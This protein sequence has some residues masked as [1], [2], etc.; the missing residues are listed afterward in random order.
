MLEPLGSVDI[1]NQPLGSDVLHDL[2]QVT[3]P[4]FPSPVST[5][6]PKLLV[7]WTFTQAQ[8]DPQTQYRV[9]WKKNQDILFDTGWQAGS[10]TQYEL[11][12]DAAP[13]LHG[14]E[15]GYVHAEARGPASLGTGEVAR[16]EASDEASCTLDWGDPHLTVTAPTADQVITDND[17]LTV[18]WTMTDDKGGATQ[19]AYR[20]WIKQ[21]STGQVL[22][23]T[24]WVTSTA[25]QVSVPFTFQDGASYDVYVQV[26]N[27]HGMR[28]D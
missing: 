26:K 18:S 21:P 24:G 27:N 22:Y 16:W 15:T 8:G 3:L 2:P 19:S 7:D 5:G 28:S 6:G 12:V 14:E 4:S 23:D 9:Y 11:D 17:G 1:G 10:Q 20:V 25:T 13:L